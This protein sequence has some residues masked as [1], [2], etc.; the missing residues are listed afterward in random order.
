[1]IKI[2][3]LRI[4]LKN[5]PVLILKYFIILFG[6]ASEQLLSDCKKSLLELQIV[7]ILFA[8]RRVVIIQQYIFKI[9]NSWG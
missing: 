2:L 9:N 4:Y 8:L 5:V 6:V 1:M 7:Y 3:V